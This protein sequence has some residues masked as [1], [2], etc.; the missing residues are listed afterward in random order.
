MSIRP[1]V[2]LLA[3]VATMVVIG[4]SATPT[5]TPDFADEEVIAVAETGASAVVPASGSL[6]LK[7]ASESIRT[8]L[9]KGA[10]P[11]GSVLSIEPMAP[12]SLP[13]LP[14]GLSTTEHAF[15][16]SLETQTGDK[17]ALS[18]DMA[19]SMVFGDA[20]VKSS[21]KDAKRL[22]I[23]HFKEDAGEWEQLATTV[24]WKTKTAS[25]FV[26]NL[27]PF[28]LL[29]RVS[30]SEMRDHESRQ[31]TV[32]LA[33][34]IQ[35]PT[36][37]PS[38]RSSL[39]NATPTPYPTYTPVPT[40]VPTPLPTPIP[41]PMIVLGVEERDGVQ[42]DKLLNSIAGYIIQHGYGHPVGVGESGSYRELITQMSAGNIDVLME[43]PLGTQG[44][45]SE[46][47][48]SLGA[49]LED[50]WFS[51]FVVPTY[52]VEQNP[53]LRT[54]YDI[55][56]YKHVFHNQFLLD[57]VGINCDSAGS[58]Q[59]DCDK[60]NAVMMG[61]LGGWGCAEQ[62]VNQLAAYGLTQHVLLAGSGSY[63]QHITTLEQ[64][65][66]S[67]EAWLGW[68][69]ASSARLIDVSYGVALTRL[70]EPPAE[71]CQDPGEGCAYPGTAAG[72][73][74]VNEKLSM[75]AP[76]VVDFVGKVYLS[77][78]QLQSLHDQNREYAK[79]NT[80]TSESPHYHT[81]I[82]FLH[83]HEDVWTD[84]VPQEVAEKVKASLPPLPEV[85]VFPTPTIV[86]IQ[87]TPFGS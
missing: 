86:P 48:E 11:T 59:Q 25:A 49:S 51:N 26:N 65:L 71:G 41:K 62:V 20:V 35:A 9:L 43:V 66:E 57:Q 77:N 39:S 19:V 42:N 76:V 15:D 8:H 78:T 64:V 10:A 81:G 2:L 82:W 85:T 33:N 84:W 12:E 36:D 14:D 54:V 50:D 18:R 16:V 32:I 75:I 21:G 22:V 4:C 67:G 30:Q 27:S 31:K 60:K 28:A 58:Y 44:I 29:V 37:R 38:P 46:N 47:I 45:D 23:G 1:I 56:S 83:N 61:C 74:A 87:V 17:V 24:E 69:S 6:V 73:I 53:R 40:P 52:V 63:G 7:N 34:P 3:L 55:A 72:V 80:N 13:P 5:P 68:M 70:E 79:G